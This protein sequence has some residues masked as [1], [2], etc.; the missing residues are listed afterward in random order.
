VKLSGLLALLDDVAAIAKVAASSVDDIATAAAKAGSKTAMVA[1]DD[2]AVTPKY[3]VG[4]S[5]E[6][7]LPIIWKIARGSLFNKL[8]V[9][10][11][12]ALLLASFAPGLIQPLLMLGGAY[13]CFEG[14]EKVY[15]A[16]VP[17]GDDA[18]ESSGQGHDPA[19][20]EET[21]V[22]GAVKTDFILSAE[23]MAIALSTVAGGSLW[24]QTATLAL[25]GVGMT[26]LVYGGVAV[27]VKLDDIGLHLART[28][29]LAA[30]R[31]FGT[32]LVWFMPVL[33]QVLSVVGTAAM[34]WVG[35]SIV[36]HGLEVTHLWA[37]PYVA[38][39]HLAEAAGQ[40][41]PAA[42]GFVVWAVGATLDGLVGLA[43]GLAL[44]PLATK[45]LGPALQRLK[46][47]RPVQ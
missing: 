7:E 35:G 43:I 37:A 47:A 21:K 28:A 31:R 5:A 27:L 29:R 10:L 34:L 44:I 23:I 42:A 1:I 24:A 3:V 25:I 6:R 8:V 2:A 18:A 39:H 20:L 38:V 17:H 32:G 12:A 26:A 45:V 41:V 14:A 4:F 11:P 33:M 13:L 16:W 19:H 46:G 15:H 30:T 40:T 22:N 36:L 9:L